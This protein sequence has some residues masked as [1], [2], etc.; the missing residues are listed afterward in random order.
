MVALVGAW[1]LDSGAPSE[2]GLEVVASLEETGLM[3]SR[4][5]A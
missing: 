5:P 2:E 1:S 3:E 4:L